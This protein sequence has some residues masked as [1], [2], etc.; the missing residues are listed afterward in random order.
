MDLEK[1]AGLRLDWEKIPQELH[2]LIPYVEKFSFDSLHAQ[3]AFVAAMQ[4]HRPEEIGLFNR[5]VDRAVQLIAEWGASL[6]LDKPAS[7]FTS[8]DWAHP[9]WAFLNVL[10]MREITGY[11]DDPDPAVKAARE[12]FNQETR[13]E[14]YYEATV[15]AD[16]AFRRGDY[17]VYVSL[18]EPFDDLLTPAQ[19]KKISFARR[20]RDK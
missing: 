8:E 19:K 20:G 10:K 2:F 9:Y 1:G 14:R 4:R 17:A 13:L 3:D 12:R 16:D 6:P 7:E 18:L 5:A 15:Q 11:A